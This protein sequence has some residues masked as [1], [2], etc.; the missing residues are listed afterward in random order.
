MYSN[1]LSKKKRK[2][3]EGVIEELMD[4]SMKKSNSNKKCEELH[5]LAEE[6][7]VNMR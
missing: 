3:Y 1:A 6:S 5:K 7:L 4:S 2:L